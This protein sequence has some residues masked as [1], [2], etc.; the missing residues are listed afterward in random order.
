MGP[1]ILYAFLAFLGFVFWFLL[2]ILWRII[3]VL[4]NLI[5]IPCSVLNNYVRVTFWRL[6]KRKVDTAIF[7]K[8]LF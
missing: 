2:K 3:V 4:L 6:P 1:E 5:L 8:T 7:K